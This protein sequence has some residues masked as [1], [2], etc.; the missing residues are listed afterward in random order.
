M[1]ESVVGS[2]V[3]K[4]Y[5]KNFIVIFLIKREKIEP[6]VKKT[7]NLTR[8]FV[9][10]VGWGAWQFVLFLSNEHFK[11]RGEV[12]KKAQRE[13]KK[14]VDEVCKISLMT[15]SNFH[16]L[17]FV[18]CTRVRKEW[19]AVQ[20]TRVELWLLCCLHSRQVLSMTF[21]KCKVEQRT[22]HHHQ[23]KDWSRCTIVGKSGGVFTKVSPLHSNEMR[24]IWYRR[25]E[26]ISRKSKIKSRGLDYSSASFQPVIF[27][28]NTNITIANAVLPC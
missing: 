5:H 28:K 9:K 18:G 13:V 27:E 12:T 26:I 25:I 23:P 7:F 20:Q 1:C 19:K 6:P 11:H 24:R 8:P 3:S 10:Q 16:I 14:A 17:T 2:G 4:K 15:L 22:L 21:I